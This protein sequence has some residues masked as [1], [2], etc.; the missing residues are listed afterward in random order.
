MSGPSHTTSRRRGVVTDEV[1]EG[2][3]E[4][5]PSATQ[6]IPEVPLT[7]VGETLAPSAE[8]PWSPMIDAVHGRM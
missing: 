6:G 3:N 8:T 7:A 4:G 5:V 1:G 2:I